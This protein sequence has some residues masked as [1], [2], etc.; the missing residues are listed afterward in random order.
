MILW[1]NGTF[2]VG[3]TTLADRLVADD[4]T[5]RL[6]DPEHVGFMLG[7]NF[8][9]VEFDDFQDLPSW[10]RLTPQIL[11]EVHDAT[12]QDVVAP[13]TVLREEYWNELRGGLER[14]GLD[15][16]HVVLQCDDAVLRRRIADDA[17]EVDARDWRLGHI[18]VAADARTWWDAA[19]DLVV[20]TTDMTVDDVART[21]SDAASS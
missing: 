10:R 16:F 20:D 9:D 7:G 15:V 3:K 18:A 19:A 6:F 8:R 12:G 17:V 2:G 5:R 4:G 13:Q 21:V 11:L 1:V 14:A